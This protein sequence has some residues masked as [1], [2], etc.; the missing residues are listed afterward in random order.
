MRPLQCPTGFR[1]ATKKDKP[2]L[3][4]FIEKQLLTVR[5]GAVRC[6]AVRCGAVR[7]AVRCGAVRCGLRHRGGDG[8]AS[9]GSPPPQRP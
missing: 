4:A 3:Q 6:G 8:R 7:G 9:A 5:C 1:R 2:L